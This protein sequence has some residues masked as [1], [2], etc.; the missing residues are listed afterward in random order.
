MMWFVIVAGIL[1]TSLILTILTAVC[2]RMI[3]DMARL[4][5]FSRY[6]GNNTSDKCTKSC[7]SLSYRKIAFYG[8]SSLQALGRH[9][10]SG[11]YDVLTFVDG[12][13]YEDTEECHQ[14]D[15][16]RSRYLSYTT[17]YHKLRKFL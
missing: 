7:H 6:N 17:P 3:A 8:F 4:M 9:I 1:V 13:T 5:L 14:E 12:I 2:W 16:K 10:I 11:L 15:E